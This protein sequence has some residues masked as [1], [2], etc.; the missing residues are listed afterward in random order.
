MMFFA[1]VFA[2]KFGGLNVFRVS[3]CDVAEPGIA[4]ILTQIDY[5]GRDRPGSDAGA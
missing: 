1:N 2:P 4:A 3:S 5:T